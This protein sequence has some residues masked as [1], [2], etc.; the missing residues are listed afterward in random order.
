[1]LSVSVIVPVYNV[2]NY[3]SRCLDSLFRQ[4]FHDYEIILID[5]GS[6]DTSGDL[7]DQS[8][9]EHSFIK[10]IHQKNQGLSSARNKGT[11][12]AT[13]KYVTYVDSDDTVDPHYLEYLYQAI[14]DTDADCA[15]A[16]RD[17]CSDNSKKVDACSDYSIQVWS[18]E[19][20][21]SE[22]LTSK[23][24]T[25]SSWNKMGLRSMYLDIP[26]PVDRYYEDI[27][28]TYRIIDC[29]E[30]CVFVDAIL[31]HYWMNPG[32][33]TGR[34]LI[35]LKQCIDYEKSIIECSSFMDQHYP[36]LSA[37]TDVLAARDYMSL[38]LSSYRCNE[39]DQETEMIRKKI[40]SWFR[41]HWKAAAGNAHA[42]REVRF[43]IWL[44]NASPALYRSVYYLAIKLYGKQLG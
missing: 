2:E 37:D 20:A 6:T 36:E 16:R 43:R 32:T 3:L 12:I 41:E 42:P 19:R 5:D 18:K 27:A 26:F 9:E 30:K 13:G 34:K 31:Y 25:V 22:V 29:C 28:H 10:V 33:I 14:I 35:S 11:Q 7:C 15:I 8:A 24:A 44:M 23:N 1:M 4:T 40:V 21:L 38:Y 39:N 17:R